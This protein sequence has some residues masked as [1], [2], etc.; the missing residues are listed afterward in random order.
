MNYVNCIKR[1]VALLS[2]HSRACDFAE[3]HADDIT[4]DI[5]FKIE[6]KIS[7]LRAGVAE[8]VNSSET[9]KIRC[10]RRK[11]LRTACRLLGVDV[12]TVLY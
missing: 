9:R 10:N 12:Y 3:R 7:D 2:A 6:D 4:V 1:I 11:Q 8:W 5:D